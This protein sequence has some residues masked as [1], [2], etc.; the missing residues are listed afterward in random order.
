M[1][2]IVKEVLNDSFMIR[3]SVPGVVDNGKA[4]PIHTMHQPKV[5]DEIIIWG[6]DE[7]LNNLFCY[8][9]VQSEGDS[10]MTSAFSNYLSNVKGSGIQMVSESGDTLVDAGNVASIQGG[11]GASIHGKSGKVSIANSAVNLSE[12]FNHLINLFVKM[13]TYA[14]AGGVPVVIAPPDD[15]IDLSTKLRLLLGK[16]E[17]IE[18]MTDGSGPSTSPSELD[19]IDLT[20]SSMEVSNTEIL[21][22]IESLVEDVSDALTTVSTLL[23]SGIASP[24]GP[25]TCPGATEVA[26]SAASIKTKAIELKLDK[27]NKLINYS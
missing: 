24:V 2:G 10:I 6:G 12:L 23:T 18:V 16:S 7:L 19:E 25:C 4:F 26:T 21:L 13:P 5:N 14:T 8:C 17:P 3:F 15:L 1:I 9:I 11:S 22:I 27:I 20:T